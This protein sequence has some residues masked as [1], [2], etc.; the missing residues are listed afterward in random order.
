MFSGLRLKT[1]F[2]RSEIFFRARRALAKKV[3]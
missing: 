2:H 1:L 3:E